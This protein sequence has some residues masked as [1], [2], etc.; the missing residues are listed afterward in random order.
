MLEVK[1]LVK[2]YGSKFAVDD[3][4]F[5][6][7][8]GEILGFLGPNGAGKT[9]T[10]NII[11]GYL[12]STQGTASVDGFEILEDPIAA[13]SRIGYLPEHP[14][15]YMDMTVKEYLNFMYDLKK[16]KLPRQKHIADI[17]E[18]VKI[19]HVYTRLI[20]NLSKGYK[21]R[22]GLAQALLGSPELLILDEP[23][24]GLDPAQII[25]IRNLIKDLGKNHTV[26]LSSH[27]LPEVQAICERVIV[28][29]EGKI[30]ADDTPD[31]LARSMSSESGISVRIEGPV[32]EVNGAI[33]ALDSV[34]SCNPM[35]ERE[36]GVFEYI[37]NPKG[38]LDVRR[39]VF[40]LT[41]EKNW[42]ILSMKSTEM[43]LEEIFL[44]L[45]SGDYA[46]QTAAEGK[47]P[48]AKPA[49]KKKAK[50]DATAKKPAEPAKPAEADEKPEQEP[51]NEDGGNA[52]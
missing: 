9:T 7:K 32:T 50:A 14:P 45:V 24:V 11:T 35:G 17:C 37:V 13:K 46:A 30:V 44:K 21:Q 25:E 28:I 47:A 40:H 15:L 27:I 33:R 39:D 8:R 42:P 2:R 23:T 12:S 51:Q 18:T 22:V 36:K 38:E 49:G 29:N 52:Q 41:A 5:S 4:T 34:Q 19:S 31:H 1:N 26:I 48:A 20:R 43:T 3:I 16:V 10:M 6:V